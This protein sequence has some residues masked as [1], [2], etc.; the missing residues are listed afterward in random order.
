MPDR[1][2][3]P[4]ETLEGSS[5]YLDC[6]RYVTQVEQYLG[7]FPLDSVLIIRSEDLRDSRA[8]TIRRVF[9]FLDVDETWL[10]ANLEQESNGTPREV[11]APR[12]VARVLA[13]A[14]GYKWVASIAPPS[15]KEL[16]RRLTM[17]NIGSDFVLSESVRRDLEERLRPEIQRPRTYMEKKFDGW[18]IGLC[19]FAGLVH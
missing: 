1:K 17:Q 8:E 6:S 5:L 7:Y 13:R 11:R 14:P 10:P 15:L 19:S 2:K 12:K 3:R 9:R 16:T 18:G 4:V